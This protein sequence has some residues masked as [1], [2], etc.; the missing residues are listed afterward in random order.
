MDQPNNRAT[1]PPAGRSILAL[2]APLILSFWMRSLFSLV[3]TV[4]ASTLG[5]AAVA[6][7]GLAIPLEF[8]MIACW[9]GLSTGLTSTLSRAMGA[10]EH[11]RVETLLATARRLVLGMVPVFTAIGLGVYLAAPR[12]GLDAEVA[13]QFAIYGSV[14]V[15]GSA[16][17][18]FWSIIPDSIV[19]AHHDTRSTMWAGIWSNVINVVLNTVFVFVFHWGVFGIALSTVLGR[20]GGLIYALRRAAALEAVR[21]SQGGEPAPS[22]EERPYSAILHLAL[23]SAAT[24]G[25]MAME[26]SLINALL[27]TLHHA[28]EAIAA[29][30]IYFRVMLFSL[31][32][33]MATSVAMLPYV[34]RRFGARD[35]DGIRRGLRQALGMGAAYCILLVAPAMLF[36]GPLIAR[37]L[38]ESE[39]TA[40]F[41]VQ[42][43]RICPLACL[44]AIPFFLLRPAFEGMG[45]GR[46]GLMMAM[47]RYLVLTAPLALV[48]SRLGREL[49][50]PGFIG[51]LAGLVAATAITSVVLSLWL[52][53]ALRALEGESRAGLP[54]GGGTSDGALTGIPDVRRGRDSYD[55]RPATRRESALEVLG[56]MSS[57]SPAAFMSSR[58][59]QRRTASAGVSMSYHTGSS[60][61][62]MRPCLIRSRVTASTSSVPQ[63]ILRNRPGWWRRHPIR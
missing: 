4:Y 54:R 22:R 8:L 47:L 45:R 19:K 7:V 14:L 51:L 18:S 1:A 15:T 57:V 52:R 6:A 49:G 63:A 37:S 27:A 29:Y 32:P 21:R 58:S 38:T 9:V 23:P 56:G 42:A 20:Y 40:G 5:D 41:T 12:L 60:W 53:S 10:G 39:V 13:R 3:D 44:V 17:S 43:L 30:S 26:S 46:P 55:N 16:A 33:I 59:R 36:L 61:Q 2:A 50:Y 25:L 48:G 62:V 24:Y 28:T 11:G 31:M 35:L 34:A